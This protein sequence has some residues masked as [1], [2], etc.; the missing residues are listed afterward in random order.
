[1]DYCNITGFG[2]SE[3]KHHL[4]YNIIKEKYVPLGL[5]HFKLEGRTWESIDLIIALCNYM[6]K[7]EYRNAVLTLMCERL[8]M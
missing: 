4:T 1:M 3:K 5:T 7:P 6:V 8:K 2:N